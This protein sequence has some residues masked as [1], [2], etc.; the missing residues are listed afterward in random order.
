MSSLGVVYGD[1]KHP[2]YESPCKP[3]KRCRA[4]NGTYWSDNGQVPDLSDFE[5]KAPTL[6]MNWQTDF[7]DITS[8]TGYKDYTLHEYSDQDYS[9]VDLHRTDRETN[10]DQFTQELRLQMD[11]SDNF[12]LLLGAF[13][14]KAEWD[15][16]QDYPLEGV[17]A[18]FTQLTEMDWETESSSVFAQAYWD[19]SDRW[20][21][22]A[23][24]RYSREETDAEVGVNNFL[25]IDLETGEIGVAQYALRGNTEFIGGILGECDG[26]FCDGSQDL[27]YV[28]ES[29]TWG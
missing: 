25:N 5:S 24:I 7:G 14:L 3:G 1:S 21:L 10:G 26:A 18:G 19:F 8:I 11:L 22:Q 6:T 20:S 4:P 13:Y 9:P 27:D 29:E 12:Q 16:Y 17:S 23:G 2:M 28:R 15:H